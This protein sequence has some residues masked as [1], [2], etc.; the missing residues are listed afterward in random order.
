MSF[1]RDPSAVLQDALAKGYSR[2]RFQQGKPVL[3]RELNLLGDLASP[4]RLA[5]Q[6]LGNGVPAGSNGF[7]VSGLNVATSDFVIEPGRCL[8]GGH[9]VTLAANTTYRTQ[10]NTGNVAAFPAGSSNVYLRSFTRP[11]TQAED[12]TLGNTGPGDVGQETAVREKA[13][14]EVLVS[15]AA[16]NARDHFLLAVI[17]TAANTVADRRRLDLTVAGVRDEVSLA[18]GSAASLG[19]RV[20]VVLADNGALRANA[21][22]EPAL[23]NGAV[24]RRTIADGAVSVL[25]MSPVPLIDLQVAVPAAPAGGVAE[26]AVDVETADEHAF[27]L[28]SVRYVAPRPAGLPPAANFLSFFTWTRRTALVKP[29][30]VTQLTHRHQIVL[31]NANN[32]AITVACKAYRIAET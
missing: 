24:S 22:A 19:A 16:I 3:D 30:G 1:S 27:H 14:W 10:P 15:A 5:D 21:V 9:E 29:T 23:A 2:V 31:Q 32:F 20:G 17:N 7:R 25:K 4:T 11:M 8:V 26:L 6:Y 12:P 28:T 13:D 18:R